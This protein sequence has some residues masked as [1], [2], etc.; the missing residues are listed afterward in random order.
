MLEDIGQHELRKGGK[1]L[2]WRKL[3][4]VDTPVCKPKEIRDVQGPGDDEFSLVPITGCRFIHIQ[5]NRLQESS[6]SGVELLGRIVARSGLSLACVLFSPTA[7]GCLDCSGALG[8]YVP[9]YSLS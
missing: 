8:E 4:V 2:R 9:M 1:P 6:L 7:G 5:N 3:T